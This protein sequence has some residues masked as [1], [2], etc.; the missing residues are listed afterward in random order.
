MTNR[1]LINI[2]AAG[3]LLTAAGCVDVENVQSDSLARSATRLSGTELGA[4]HFEITSLHFVVSAYGRE[5][6]QEYS[7]LAENNYQEIMEETGLYSFVPAQPYEIVIYADRN[8]YLQKSG[9]P[10]WSGGMTMGNAVLLYEN[11]QLPP[12]MAHEMTHLVFNEFMGRPTPN[13]RWLNEGLAVHMELAALGGTAAAAYRSDS[14][15]QLKTGRV[16]FSQM[17]AFVP[18]DEEAGRVNL[19]YRQ[20][21]SV[22]TY[23][24]TN[25]GR[26]AF[27]IFLK[28]LRDGK[29]V[30]T[31]LRDAFPGK[32][33]GAAELEQL[34]IKQ[35]ESA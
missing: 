4:G 19:W 11:D 15:T 24:L 1:T 5:N 33:D 32:W 22:A 35:L 16:P 34:W 14:R 10:Q 18:R 12:V 31:A 20:C 9:Q 6:A 21:E 28:E 26:L 2:A 23:L 7:D 8:E 17:F 13:L 30:D 25:G 27:S 3:L 29:S